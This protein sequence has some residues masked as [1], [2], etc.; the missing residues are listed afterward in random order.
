MIAV[1]AGA[2]EGC[3][4]AANAPPTLDVSFCLCGNFA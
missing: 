3:D 2:R 1:D 4:L